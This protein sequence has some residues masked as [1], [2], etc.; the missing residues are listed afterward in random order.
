MIHPTAIVPSDVELPADVEIGPYAILESGIK[1]GTGCRIHSHAQVL[2]GTWMGD[3]NTIGHAAIIGGLPQ[4]LS[5][6]PATPSHL[7][8]GDGNTFR[9]HVTLH[10]SATENESTTLGSRNFFMA[11]SH[12]GHDCQIGDDNIVANAC[13]IAG[14]VEMGNH[15][16]LGG[17]S[18]YHQFLRIGDHAMAQGN[19]QFSK[20]IPPFVTAALYNR[21]FGLNSIGIRRSGVG[22]EDRRSLKKLY[23]LV[24]CGSLNVS[25][26][27]AQANE[28]DWAGPAQLLLNFVASPSKKGICSAQKKD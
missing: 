21:L 15:C 5:F 22:P 27:V 4:D 7:R 26:A 23:E 2:T 10:R 9:E 12:V 17:G 3:G 25:Q 13:L 19:G 11:G 8:I 18:V 1:I 14:H 6:D 16:F 20:D 28:K 24:F